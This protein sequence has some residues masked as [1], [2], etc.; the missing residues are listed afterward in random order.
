MLEQQITELVQP[1]AEENGAT[2][3][4]VRMLQQGGPVLQVLLEDEDGSSPTIEVCQVVSRELGHILDVEDIMPEA[5]NLEVSSPGM[6]RPLTRVEDYQRFE[7]KQAK[8]KLL[9]DVE[10]RKA[11]KGFL[12]G[13]AENMLSLK[14]VE[15]GE[16]ISFAFEDVKEARLEPTEEDIAALLKNA[17]K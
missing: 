4:C 9:V 2:V 11:H 3:V 1:L 7:G 6:S 13:V 17:K 5:Y 10:G 14:L 12:A 8:V 15:G 16:T